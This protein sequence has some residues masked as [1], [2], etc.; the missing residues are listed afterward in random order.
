MKP[1]YLKNLLLIILGI[2]YAY[3]DLTLK[4]YMSFLN[5]LIIDTG[6]STLYLIKLISL[7]FP[8]IV[9]AIIVVFVVLT[10]YIM[11]L[12][13]KF[14][15]QLFI[16]ALSYLIFYFIGGLKFQAFEIIEVGISLGIFFIFAFL[17][18]KIKE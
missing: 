15:Y 9:S 1:E 8:T 14:N 6:E 3:A 4:L 17:V 7:F 18:K 5:F 13:A 2:G 12:K 11:V 16:P 10:I